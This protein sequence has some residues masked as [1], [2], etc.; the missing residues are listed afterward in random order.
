MNI[1]FFNTIALGDY[2]IHSNIL[3]E[4]KKKYNCRLIAVCSPYNSKIIANEEHID[5]VI[6]YDKKFN[7]LKK[8]SVL[9]KILK[10]YYYISLVADAQKFSY[11]ANFILK[12]KH[13]RG[14][15]IKKCK[16]IFFFNFNF[17]RPFLFISKLIFNKYEVQTQVKYLKKK[18]HLPSKFLKLFADF[19]IKTNETYFF[20]KT[21]KQDLKKNSI[22]KK[23]KI[24]KYI[25]IHMDFKWSDI[26]NIEKKL[27]DNITKLHN[28]TK[29]PILI[30]VYKNK[31]KY[32]KIFEKKNNI[33]NINNNK[34][35]YKFKKKKI[36]ILKDCDLF[37]EERIISKSSWN[38]SC[39]AGILVHSAAS[40]K[41]NIID[42]IPKE[43]FL[44]QSCWVPKKNYFV[45]AKRDKAE[46]FDI[47]K[48]FNNVIKIITKKKYE[49]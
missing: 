30:F 2:L 42:I 4:L 43:Q 14:I 15:I 20:N 32:F 46:K 37:L 21:K 18:E 39:H 44:Y 16:K 41:R 40:N 47:N 25:C 13:K 31:E 8:I 3:N 36:F 19:K 24:K 33:L 22:L 5:E 9:K 1:I 34:I 6:L 11:F 23:L 7:F 45:I 38:I 17:Y 28:A 26:K 27:D 10:G 35:F 49:Y 48:I 29:L 12:A